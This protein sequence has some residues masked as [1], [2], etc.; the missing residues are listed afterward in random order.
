MATV[1]TPSLRVPGYDDGDLEPL[2]AMPL[3][4]PPPNH[5]LLNHYYDTLDDLV[6]DLQDWSA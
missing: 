1:V 2:M 4:N 5:K 6:D 3:S